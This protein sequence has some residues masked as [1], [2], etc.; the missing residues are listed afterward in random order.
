MPTNRNTPL[1]YILFRLK[2]IDN[3]MEILTI[4]TGVTFGLCLIL[5]KRVKALEKEIKVLTEEG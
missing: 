2:K 4:A 5:R 1:D 3:R